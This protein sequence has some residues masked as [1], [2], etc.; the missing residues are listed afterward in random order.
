MRPTILS[1]FQRMTIVTV[2]IM[3][4]PASLWP[5]EAKQAQ[6]YD[7]QISKAEIYAYANLKFAGDYARFES[8]QG[9]AALGRTE[10]GVTLV[11]IV[12][13]GTL[14][15]EAPEA[16]QEKFKTVF[17]AH[18]LRIA[19]KSL[20][21]RISPKEFDEV[22]AAQ[23]K[24]KAADEN[25]FTTA[26]ALFDERFTASWHAGSKA[27]LPPLKTRVIEI[28][29]PEHGLIATEEGYWLTLR[30]YTPYASVYPRD[31]VNPKQK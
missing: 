10:A 16:V 29:T 28:R 5:Q 11:V 24:T 14:S 1:F 21:M 27:M 18:P 25:T 22:L 9:F 3:F 31:F 2:V 17:G 7:V 8:A 19:F 4:W 20:Y 15:I 6:F 30:R 26:K 12:G 13:D 23:I